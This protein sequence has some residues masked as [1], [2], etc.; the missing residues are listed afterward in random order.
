MLD[1]GFFMR[2]EIIWNKAASSGGSC[3]WGSWMSANNPTLRDVHEYI[4]IFR[5]GEKKR[6]TPPK[7]EPRY[8]S[9]YFW[10]ERNIWFSD[11]WFDIRGVQQNLNNN[12]KLRERSAAYPLELP[13]R[14]INMFSMYGDTVI[15]PFWGT[16][17]TSIAAMILARN[18]IGYEINPEFKG[19]FKRNLNKVKGLTD[20]INSNR[21]E[22]HIKF[23]KKYRRDK[24]EPKYISKNYD[25]PIITSQEVEIQFYSIDKIHEN[26]NEYTIDHEKYDYEQKKKL[27]QSRLIP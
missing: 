10:E 8:N 14:L 23:I 1:I 22:D 17:T 2:G 19:I 11:I 20:T 26:E 16:G 15:D 18:S 24:K 21:I 9:A 6:K 4:L 5:K 12:G 3:A 25:F 7:S 13:Y 27:V